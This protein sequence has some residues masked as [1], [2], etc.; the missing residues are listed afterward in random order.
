MLSL[1][2]LQNPGFTQTPKGPLPRLVGMLAGGGP[3]SW[4]PDML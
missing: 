3:W 1:H 2:S 4:E